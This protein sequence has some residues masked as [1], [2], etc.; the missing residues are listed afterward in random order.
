MSMVT[1][2]KE[3]FLFHIQANFVFVFDFGFFHFSL[4]NFQ[5]INCQIFTANVTHISTTCVCV[6]VSVWAVC[7]VC[8]CVWAVGLCLTIQIQICRKAHRA[9]NFLTQLKNLH[10][11]RLFSHFFFLFTLVVVAVLCFEN[12]C[13]SGLSTVCLRANLCVHVCASG[14]GS[15]T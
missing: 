14:R 2:Q 10:K 3:L 13:N 15:C 5:N 11:F 12:S 1:I 6:C 9:D 4:N 8:V 7:A